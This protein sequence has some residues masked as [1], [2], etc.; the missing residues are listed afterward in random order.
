MKIYIISL[1]Y[2]FALFFSI[3]S[4][5]EQKKF[6]WNNFYLLNYYCVNGHINKKTNKNFLPKNIMTQL[7]MN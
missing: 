7:Q 1:S 2:N 5:I 6:C 3:I 4:G